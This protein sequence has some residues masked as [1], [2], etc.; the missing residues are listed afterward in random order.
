MIHWK[1]NGVSCS[2]PWARWVAAPGG[3]SETAKAR[4]VAGYLN[5]HLN[6]FRCKDIRCGSQ[7]EH[8]INS[9]QQNLELQYDRLAEFLPGEMHVRPLAGLFIEW[10]SANNGVTIVGDS[11]TSS[12]GLSHLL[13]DEGSIPATDADLRAGEAYWTE[14]ANVVWGECGL[15]EMVRGAGRAAAVGKNRGYDVSAH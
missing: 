4:Q 10:Q 15:G 14:Y 11:F 6:A 12:E 3:E 7:A 8:I 13:H 9:K 2:A 1:E 5:F